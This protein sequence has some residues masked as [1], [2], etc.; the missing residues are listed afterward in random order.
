MSFPYTLDLAFDS[1]KS[2]ADSFGRVSFVKLEDNKDYNYKT[3]NFIVSNLSPAPEYYY[4]IECIPTSEDVKK[5][6]Y[7][8]LNNAKF[9]IVIFNPGKGSTCTIKIEYTD[10]EYSYLASSIVSTTTSPI[11]PLFIPSTKSLTLNKKPVGDTTQ[12]PIATLSLHL[13]NASDNTDVT[14]STVNASV[15]VSPQPLIKI[16]V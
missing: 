15:S 16:P 14:D 10:D 3:N 12:T 9:S 7:T 11:E 5:E 13:K 6:V 4:Y 2:T 8:A 1:E